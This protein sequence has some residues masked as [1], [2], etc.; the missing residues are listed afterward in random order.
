MI[1]K[2][3]NIFSRVQLV[4]NSI[5]VIAFIIVGLLVYFDARE[6]VYVE[7]RE[8]MYLEIE[9]LSHVIDIYRVRDRDILNMAANFGEYKINEYSD[10]EESDSAEIDFEAV[11]PI[12]KNPMNIKIHEWFVDEMSLVDN[13]YIVDEIKTL[14]RV[15][16]SIYQKTAKG[17]VNI[18]TNIVN[19]Q[20]DRM[21]G[22]IVLN[23][24]D[25]VQTVESGNL[26]RARFNKNKSWYQTIYKPI[27]IDGK[28]RG[29]Y[30]VSLK[31]RIGRA[32][33]AIFDKRKYFKDGYAFIMTK[34][35]R[36]TIHPKERGMDYSK[37]IMFDKLNKLDEEK[38]TFM[39]LWPETEL[40]DS[41][42]LSFKYEKSINS[43]VCIA[44]P[45]KEV[46][47]HLNNRFLYIT[48]WFALFVIVFQFALVYL[49]SNRKEKIKLV[50]K[51]I[52]K[53]AKD[54]RTEKLGDPEDEYGQVYSNINLISEKYTMLENYVNKLVNNQLGM[55]LP[56]ILKNDVIANTLTKVDKK[57]IRAD[58][59]EKEGDKEANL[60]KW[61]SDGLSKFI[62]ILQQ[63]TD[64]IQELSY[65]LVNNLVVYLNANQGA[66]FFIN[67]EKVNDVYF[68]QMATYAYDKKRLITKKIYPEEGLIGRIYNEKKTIY[69]SEIPKNYI[70]ITSGLGELEPNYLLIV[71]LL[72]NM[73]VYGALEIA[74]FNKFE[75]Y[76]IEFIEKIGE[77]IASTINN[78]QINTRTRKLLEQSQ[79]QKDQKT[80]V[81]SKEVESKSARR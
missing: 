76:Q 52:A 70:K 68:E 38:G 26:Y 44:F 62:G 46:F 31:E 41:W 28:I 75:D 32:L 22:D 7:T 11:N 15:N 3:L 6:D 30:F 59:L 13:F 16:A 5:L 55:N 80:I 48:F 21:L 73:E 63:H 74:S 18:S 12:T 39:Y 1:L 81:Q 20:E 69:L 17:Y 54:G 23:S 43:Y 64:N 72:L 25:I 50:S 19:T 42:Y 4:I 60:R 10:F 9:E 34:E 67:N 35:G 71:P 57:L 61:E 8:Q 40:T 45:K 66:L 58:K 65:Q 47:K 2:Q 49:N 51:S 29:M 24:S 79:D 53:I 78:V 33:K 56:D 14:S 37:T 27:Y 36:L 77:N